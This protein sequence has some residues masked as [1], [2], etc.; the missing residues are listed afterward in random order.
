MSQPLPDPQTNLQPETLITRTRGGQPGNAT[1]GGANALKHGFYS[2]V[3]RRRE[4]EDLQ[5]LQPFDLEEEITMLRIYIRRMLEAD[6]GTGDILTSRAVLRTLVLV[7]HSI[8]RLLKAQRFLRQDE[9]LDLSQALH[10]G[11]Q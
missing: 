5:V 6:D 7:C 9:Q 2:R 4:L 1:L 11:L 8:T 10:H 3:W